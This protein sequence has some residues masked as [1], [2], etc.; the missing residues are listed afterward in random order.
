MSIARLPWFSSDL[1]GI[2][3][4]PGRCAGEGHDSDDH[5]ATPRIE[6]SSSHRRTSVHGSGSLVLRL[7]ARQQRIG[8]GQAARVA[9]VR[10]RLAN[11]RYRSKGSAPTGRFRSTR[12]SKAAVSGVSDRARTSCRPHLRTR[13]WRTPHSQP[14]RASVCRFLPQESDS[15]TRICPTRSRRAA[16]FGSSTPTDRRVHPG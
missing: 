5:A 11:G 12:S 4:A 3:S 13:E 6:D 10:T 16:R 8:L 1:F 15:A 9:I 14:G 2:K 7:R